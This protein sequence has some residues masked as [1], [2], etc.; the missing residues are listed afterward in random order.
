MTAAQSRYWGHSFTDAAGVRKVRE[1]LGYLPQTL[2]FYRGFTARE[3]VEYVAWLRR[4]PSSE[5]PLA[6]DRALSRVDLAD[7]AD[8]KLRKL[9]G[10]MQR[11]VGVA[12]AI[13][14]DPRLL[15]LD[16]PT[17]GLDPEQRVGF[18]ELLRELGSDTC[19]VVST[20]LVE[21]VAHACDTVTIMDE[22]RVVE[23]TDPHALAARGLD[24][25]S[26]GDSAVERGY[27]ATLRTSRAIR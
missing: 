24:S 21:D 9:S 8:T 19:V 12:Q 27:T 6:A 10:G 2:G 20:H 11:R 3:Y 25:E 4:M 17:V 13:V 22:G 5:I 1:Q 23:R 18:R 7:R 16:E 26:A 15:L 14:N